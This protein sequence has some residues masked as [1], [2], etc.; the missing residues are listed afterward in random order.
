[1]QALDRASTF[2]GIVVVVVA[3]VWRLT[4][5]WLFPLALCVALYGVLETMLIPNLA[6][7]WRIASLGA[8]VCIPLACLVHSYPSVTVGG[9]V[10]AAS[11]LLAVLGTYIA[12]ARWPYVLSHAVSTALM[13][14]ILG[15][16]LAHSLGHSK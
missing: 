3:L 4:N 10:L 8:H 15:V 9:V 11:V 6:W 16:L 2:I 14:S 7:K 1:M 5:E 13:L 12:M